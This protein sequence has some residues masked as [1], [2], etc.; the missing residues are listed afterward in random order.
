MEP[1]LERQKRSADLL[2]AGALFTLYIALGVATVHRYGVT[3]DEPEHWVFGDR[4][5][6]FYLTLD[7]EALDFSSVGWLPF[8]TWP[9]GPTLAAL[10]AK[11]FSERLGLVDTN[12]GHHLASIFLMGL[13]LSALYLFMATHAGRIA[14]ILSCVALATHPRIWGDAHNNSQDI[15]HIVFYALC[16]LTFVHAMST[17]RAR[18]LLVSAICWGFALGSK[19]N[20]LSLP[21]VVAP[22]LAPLLWNWTRYTGPVRRS[23]AAYPLIAL[24]VLFLTW[25]YFWQSPLD[26][27]MKL[28][29]YVIW[30]GYAGPMAFQ[31]S[32]IVSVLV[33][34]PLPML[35]C[36]LL[37][38]FTSTWTGRPFGRMANLTLLAW[39][40][41]PIIRS[42]APGVLNYD[43]IRRFSEFSPSL[44]IFAGI[45][46][47]SLAK[48]PAWSKLLSL[49][50]GGWAFKMAVIVGFLSPIVAIW[51]YFPYEG[52]YYNPL[53]GGLG[54]AQSLKLKDSTDYDFSSYREGINWINGHA[55]PGSLLIVPQAP[56]LIPFYPLRKGLALSKRLWMDDLSAEGRTVYLM[57]VTGELAD[58]NVCLAEAFLRPEYEVRRDGGVLLKIYRLPAKSP[59]SVAR[60]AF[61]G[62]QQFSA[63]L[64]R[65]WITLSWKPTPASDIV[66][67]I[68]YY[69]RAPGQYDGS[70]CYRE[71]ANQWEFFAAVPAATYYLSLSALSQQARES[72]RTPDIVVELSN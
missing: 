67:H 33:T 9:V 7:Q 28:S 14:A 47:A 55:D 21:V 44:A 71:K 59:L 2:L 30:W 53:V 58:Y 29:S 56:H 3:L 66:G 35:V 43:V 20:A 61:P 40:L 36:A 18:W 6:E 45:G 31:I 39:L 19:I 16:I 22:M 25:P 49:R 24:S 38:I 23:L 50:R 13:L 34:T 8:Q 26:R 5:L 41:V 17:Q 57:Y 54:G 10:T 48:W 60:N 63:T 69:G 1:Q 32:P 64:K 62:P 46:G 12:D 37:G 52:T 11:L 70:V 4:Y 15:P 72:Q 51:R 27:L 68:L 65:R 42:T